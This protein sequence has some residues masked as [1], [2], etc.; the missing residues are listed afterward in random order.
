[1]DKN[2]KIKFLATADGLD[3]IF[4][5]VQK[6]T[7]S[8][9]ISLT[10]N[11]S[12][13]FKQAEIAL[14][15]LL[16]RAKEMSEKE[17]FSLFDMEQL[18]EDSKKAINKIS[19]VINSLS[20]SG[21]SEKFKKELEKIEQA[22]ESK[23]SNKSSLQKENRN[24]SKRIGHDT[25]TGLSTVKENQAFK[26]AA[27]K[28]SD[29]VADLSY[30][31]TQIAS[32]EQLAKV[33][34]EINSLAE[35]EKTRYQELIDVYDQA[36]N[37]LNTQLETERNKIA[38]NNKSIATID[39][40][41]QSLREKEAEIKKQSATSSEQADY[42]NQ[43]SNAQ[44][45]LNSVEGQQEQIIDNVVEQE[46]KNAK[47]K[48]DSSDAIKKSTIDI[49]TNTDAHTKNTTTIG[50]A[51]KQVFTYGTVLS[52]FRRIYSTVTS[53]VKE[54]DKALTDM[55]VVTSMSREDAYKL[56]GQ[57]N[58]LAAA[59]G[60]T[61]TEIANMATK[62]YQQG[63]STTQVLKLTEAAAKAATIAGID[64]SKSID[65]LT[66]ALNGF[67][68]SANQAMEVS[69]KFA[70]LAASAATDYEELATALSKVA[71]Q[72]NLAG[73]SMDFTLGL[74]TKGIET[75]REAPETIGTALKTVISRMREL[76]DY[77][78]TLEDGVD[79]NRVDQALQNVGISLMDTNGQF[80]DLEVVLTELGQKWDDLNTNQQ[81]N[82][83]V[84][85]AGTRQQ[86]RLIAMMQDFDR[87]LELVDISANSYG[88]TLAQS[89][90]YMEGFEAAQTRLTNAMQGLI[91]SVIDTDW[92]IGLL[93]TI[94]FLINMLTDNL[95]I[96]IP[97][98][99]MLGI[100]G[101][102]ALGTKIQE[103]TFEREQL[104]LKQ[105]AALL[106]KER[107]LSEQKHHNEQ[108]IAQQKEKIANLERR[109]SDLEHQKALQKQSLENKKRI[110]DNIRLEK[111]KAKQAIL[112]DT[113]LS[114]AE[115]Q[116]KLNQLDVK[117][118]DDL[119]Q[120]SK[121]MAKIEQQIAQTDTKIVDTEKEIALEKNN[122]NTMLVDNVNYNEA[123]H[124]LQKAQL[125]S[126]GFL[127]KTFSGLLTILGS[128][129]TVM[130][131]ITGLQT[132]LNVLLTKEQKERIKNFAL[133]V[134]E[135]AIA[136]GATL[137]QAA[138]TAFTGPFPIGLIL[139]A[140]LLAAAGVAIA[141]MAGAFKGEEGTDDSIAKTREELNQLQA[142][143]YNLNQARENVAKL[144]D[145]FDSLSNKII[146]TEE[147]LERLKEIGQQINDEAGREV[148]DLNASYDV[149]LNQIKGYEA[150][151]KAQTNLKTDEI[152]DTLAEGL[153]KARV[154]ASWTAGVT[155]E[156]AEEKYR[157]ELVTDS[158]FVNAA[159]T[160]AMSQLESLNTVSTGTRDLVMDMF[161]DALGNAEG[162]TTSTDWGDELFSQDGGIDT[163]S[164]VNKLGGGGQFNAFLEQLDTTMQNGSFEA[165][166]E[167][168]KQIE[169]AAEKG[170]EA[171]QNQLKLLKNSNP[172]F[173]ALGEMGAETMDKFVAIGLGAEEMNTISA[174]L[175]QQSK[176]LKDDTGLADM[177][178][179][180][181]EGNNGL[182]D[183]E[184]LY[185]Q[186]VERQKQAQAAA[187][188]YVNM[189]ADELKT[190]AE[191]G[192]A[193]AQQYVDLKNKQEELEKEQEKLNNMED[194]S[195]YTDEEVEAQQKKVDDAAEEVGKL[196][197]EWDALTEAA[198]D[199]NQAIESFK[200]ILGS[201]PIGDIVDDM[202]K[203]NSAMERI[204]KAIGD[205]NL[206][207]KDQIELLGEYPELLGAMERGYLTMSEAVQF[208]EEQ[209]AQ[210][211]DDMQKSMNNMGVVYGEGTVT[212]TGMNEWT[213]YQQLFAVGDEGD[214]QRKRFLEMG[215]IDLSSTD[216]QW[217][218]DFYKN[219]VQ[220][221]V[222]ARL[223]KGEKNADGSVKSEEDIRAEVEKSYGRSKA[224]EEVQKIR[225]DVIEYNKY[226]VALENSGDITA[227]LTEE[228]KEAWATASD[229]SARNRAL[230]EQLNSDL[231][232]MEEGSEQYKKTLDDR[233][234]LELQ[235]IEDDK[236]YLESLKKRSDESLDV[237]FDNGKAASEYIEYINGQAFLS[238]AATAELTKDEQNQ[239]SIMI[240]QLNAF[241]EETKEVTDRIKESQKTLGE[242]YIK[243]QVEELEKLIKV[244][245]ENIA[246]LEEENAALEKQIEA[247]E[248]LKTKYEETWSTLDALEEEQERDKSRDDIIRQ[249]SAL[250]GGSDSAT[251]SLRKDLMQQ[252]QDLQEEEREAAKQEERD[253]LTKSIDDNISSIEEKIASNEQL[254][255]T[256]NA[257]IEAINEEKEAIED[258]IN[259]ILTQLIDGENF[260]L[261]RKDDGSIVI[262]QKNS[263]GQYDEF[264]MFKEGGKVDYTGPAWVDGTPSKP[265][266]FLSAADTKNMELLLNALQANLNSSIITSV[267]SNDISENTQ[268]NVSIGQ[269]DIHTDELN[270]NQDF[271]DASQ[272]FATEFANAVQRRGLN[273]NVKK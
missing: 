218:E 184:A 123:A 130:T 166:S 193:T 269:V 73:M 234:K 131:T 81:A 266:A 242:V 79:V 153:T 47:A 268:V 10:E 165:Y 256:S 192:D 135:K 56:T 50:K 270:N 142:D 59:T 187:I 261:D 243:Q 180:I 138:K 172:I 34:K 32:Y 87:T 126:A 65:L 149:Q 17:N 217:F 89:A 177:I 139:G 52:I 140:A 252:L 11:L 207:L 22:I 174:A 191:S 197:N 171:A 190:L 223:D 162:D 8:N 39:K 168:Y 60:K 212:M 185:K 236:A 170:D 7:N 235:S 14:K 144:G 259:K 82:V 124:E 61:T 105:Q 101:I 28:T 195:G 156:R 91:M 90:D 183:R 93:D 63:K 18:E 118:K 209:L 267:D 248:E 36:T 67:Q 2:I 35:E 129:V 204:Q 83:A 208:S 30:K 249:L 45:Q 257:E 51:A 161:V 27:G 244:E 42:I 176:V 155:R 125:D 80:R 26:Q 213:D 137:L 74:L 53:T 106:E 31:D 179:A 57:F 98:V 215:D 117:Y 37:S 85:L 201:V 21:M 107:I 5:D 62:F 128:I 75:T 15:A 151:L 226:K 157:Q 241:A 251:N 158:S 1:M 227:L 122:L 181:E 262:L 245:E 228:Q 6:I 143:L 96:M 265:E 111:S 16:T 258:G 225:A 173:E 33:I 115:R 164:F 54:L 230:I 71:A 253:A 103:L 43:L 20:F 38:A 200:V 254:I 29:N 77:G 94:T 238:A 229:A 263:A 221:Q 78:A 109:K 44:A 84:A 154:N 231:E 132:L 112:D 189:T 49:N 239:L 216:N 12:K 145:E 150:T 163:T 3:K 264:D 88:A 233:N 182:V 136:L 148:V 240:T 46:R 247:Q 133:M 41:I 220:Q 69:D 205:T 4:K 114:D 9:N 25:A 196:Q 255:E 260:K 119:M 186:M 178:T 152:N 146:K 19:K 72:A 202:T 169:E 23:K 141:A 273:L 232:N 237:T 224:R 110:K 134:K 100:M 271:A 102:Q 167:M 203:L 55:A 64:G 92:F 272:V 113:S 24:I 99:T 13:D 160:V 68:M 206:A 120:V 127:S 199:S 70:A 188:G 250:E 246:K 104:K 40:E 86:S 219:N 211:K 66:N 58:E 214:A 222:Q 95:W 147:E 97:I 175:K 210:S 121:D 108:E 116:Y 194:N 159:R 48:K 76:T 198:K